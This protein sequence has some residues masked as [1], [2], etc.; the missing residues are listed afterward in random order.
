MAR[1]V[2][3]FSSAQKEISFVGAARARQNSFD[4]CEEIGDQI[5][6]LFDFVGELLKFA[7]MLEL[8]TKLM[9]LGATCA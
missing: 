6:G 8:I 2:L 5:I 9:I 1:E 4:P 7:R 3:S